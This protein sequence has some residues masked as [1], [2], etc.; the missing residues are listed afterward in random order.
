[1]DS[2]AWDRFAG[3]GLGLSAEAIGRIRLH[4]AELDAVGAWRP[5]L[6]ACRQAILDQLD[7]P[8]M[9]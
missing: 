6:E 8:N 7:A 3:Q 2:V 9:P 5:R 4:L 1:M